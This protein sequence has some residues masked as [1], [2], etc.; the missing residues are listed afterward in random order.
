VRRLRSFVVALLHVDGTPH[1]TALAFGL[2][3]FIAFSPLL[4]IHTGMAL[5]LAFACRLSRVAIL[6]GAY[7]NNPWTLAPMY[8]A[9]TLV[10]CQML[11][12]SP[13]G[14]SQINW[15]LHGRAFYSALIESLWPYFWPYVVGNTALGA[16]CG[17]VGYLALRA[18]LERRRA[19]VVQT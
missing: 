17:L 10:G 16:V 18:I 8:M 7:I 13:G 12:V 6:T 19:A 1:R 2:G 4:G 9:G 5:A 3:V 11:G 14:L 15:H